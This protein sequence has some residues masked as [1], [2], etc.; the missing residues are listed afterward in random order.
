M[1]RFFRAGNC[2]NFAW[3]LHH[4]SM[5]L[6][7]E[8]AV[9]FALMLGLSAFCTATFRRAAR[10]Q[11]KAVPGVRRVVL[12]YLGL[13]AATELWAATHLP[14]LGHSD[15][16]GLQVT[17]CVLGLPALLH[18]VLLASWVQSRAT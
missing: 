8:S 5:T 9:L 6:I 13:C 3:L 15:A 1:R 17:L 16:A 12:P 7:D 10:V 4:G 2:A 18:T 14:H 11:H